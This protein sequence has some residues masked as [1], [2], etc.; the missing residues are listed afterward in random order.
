MQLWKQHL[1]TKNTN[2]LRRIMGWQQ[3]CAEA[4]RSNG[5]SRTVA[6]RLE[7]IARQRQQLPGRVAGAG[8]R[9]HILPS[10]LCMWQALHGLKA[11]QPDQAPCGCAAS[12]GALMGHL[13]NFTLT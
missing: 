7:Y 13:A 6:E 12:S 1:R 5:K 2:C 3:G 8:Y 11:V 9:F 10:E 4:D